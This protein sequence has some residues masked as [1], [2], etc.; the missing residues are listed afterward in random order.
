MADPQPTLSISLDMSRTGSLESQTRH[1]ASPFSSLRR[2]TDRNFA[3]IPV[4]L[5]SL[6]SALCDS[7]AFNASSVL[8]STQTGNTVFLALGAAPGFRPVR[9]AAAE[10]MARRDKASPEPRAF[11]VIVLLAFRF[12][13]QIVA[14][15]QLGFNEVPANVLTSVYCGLFSDPHILA[16]WRENPKRNRRAPTA[17]FIVLRAIAGGWLGRSDAGW[18]SALWIV[19]GVKFLIGVAWLSGESRRCQL[20]RNRKK[21][22]A[23]CRNVFMRP[24]GVT[25][26]GGQR[27]ALLLRKLGHI[28]ACTELSHDLQGMKT[29]FLREKAPE[30]S[31]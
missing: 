19:G 1:K 27:N 3:D 5:C 21:K 23:R 31:E 11:V 10:A 15:R 24:C 8:V 30:A 20:A 26:Q 25:S 12:G 16:P 22:T 4:C 2:D 13:C 7:A 29:P 28:N 14:S 9:V 17:V 6:V 18:G